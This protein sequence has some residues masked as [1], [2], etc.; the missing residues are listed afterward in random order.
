MWEKQD[1]LYITGVDTIKISVE[2]FKKLGVE[3]YILAMPREITGTEM[4]A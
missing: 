3:V 1:P 2:F 4:P